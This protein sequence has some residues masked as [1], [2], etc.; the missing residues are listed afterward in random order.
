MKVVSLFWV[1]MYV[2]MKYLQFGYDPDRNV[3]L[4]SRTN[5]LRCI[6]D[7]EGQRQFKG[8]NFDYVT[9]GGTFSYCDDNSLV[10]VSN[11]VCIDLDHLDDDS[12]KMLRKISPKEMKQLL[13]QDPYFGDKTLLMYTSP[14]GHGIKWLVEVDMDQCD[15][16]TWFNAL[17]NYL[18]TTYGLGEKQVD[19]TVA[20]V[21]HGCFVSY[22]PEAYLRADQYE[23]FV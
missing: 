7:E 19:S 21:S 3:D 10:E 2:T 4:V 8:K 23:F 1:W 13:L 5:T 22:D 20:H 14:R 6:T 15:Y 16:K 18:M 12:E 17:R 9:P 11:M